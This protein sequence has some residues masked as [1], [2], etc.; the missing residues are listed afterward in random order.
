L[1]DFREKSTILRGATAAAAVQPSHIAK[2][3][4]KGRGDIGT[5]RAFV[6]LPLCSAGNA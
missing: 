5:M 6:A 2:S 1:Q 3:G 4:W